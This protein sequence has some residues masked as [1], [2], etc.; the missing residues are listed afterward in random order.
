ME[1]SR[2]IGEDDEQTDRQTDTEEQNSIELCRSLCFK[3][4]RQSN[5]LI[6]RSDELAEVARGIDG[7]LPSQNTPQ[8]V[9]FPPS[10]ECLLAADNEMLPSGAP[11]KWNKR[12]SMALLQFYGD[13]EHTDTEDDNSVSSPARRLRLAKKIGVTRSQ[14][15]FAQ[16]H[17]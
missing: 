3:T 9:E 5:S 1:V 12:K 2:L 6:G 13:D 11:N 16:M 17:L 15:N 7:K 8:A 10:I 4:Q 14:L